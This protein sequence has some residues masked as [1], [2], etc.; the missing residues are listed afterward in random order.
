MNGKDFILPFM[1]SNHCANGRI[2]TLN[3]SIGK[4]IIAHDY[5]EPVS[6]LLTELLII[7]C[8]L[9]QNLKTEGT[10]TCQVQSND[11]AI[12]LLVSE[13]MYGGGIRGYAGFD[14]E[15]F[16]SKEYNLKEL[17][18]SAQ[19]VVTYDT[20]EHKYQGIIELEKESLAKS[21]EE[22]LEKSDQI[23]AVV[24][25]ATEISNVL[26]DKTISS[27]GI[28][29]TKMPTS[30]EDA[31]DDW[32]KYTHFINTITQDE[33]LKIEPEELLRRLFHDDGV[34]V[35]DQTPINFKCRCT[36]EKMEN[37]LNAIPHEEKEDLRIDGEIIIKCQFCSKEEKF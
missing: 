27:A 19:L 9:G 15:N 35:Y 17:I 12:R 20:K 4:I 14:H 10:I 31:E 1:I 22:Y 21:F 32:I 37:A 6:K 3:D 29:L 36:R 28:I 5:P 24:S 7:T 25:I 16:I 18:G 11:G 34:L 33:L 26:D 8:F 30:Y 2:V 13:F 23:K